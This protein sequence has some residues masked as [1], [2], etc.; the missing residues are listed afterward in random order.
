MTLI[1]YELQYSRTPERLHY[2]HQKEDLCTTHA[3][4]LRYERR[5]GFL[6][7]TF[8]HLPERGKNDHERSTFFFHPGTAMLRFDVVLCV[9]ILK[10][11]APLAL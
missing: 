5:V 9:S 7:S 10:D 1:L 11:A 4:S 3:F 8:S 6:S 2:F